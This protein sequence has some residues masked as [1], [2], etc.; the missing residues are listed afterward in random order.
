MI[1]IIYFDNFSRETVCTV[2]KAELLAKENVEQTLLEIFSLHR[3]SFEREKASLYI[4]Y[5]GEIKPF[6]LPL[7]SDEEC[8]EIIV[9][10]V[11]APQNA[12]EFARE[13]GIMYY[14]H[15]AEQSHKCFPHIHAEYS[16]ETISIYLNDFHTVGE[17]KNKKAKE[18]VA[19][20]RKNAKSIKAEWNKIMQSQ[21]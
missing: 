3:Y 11:V 2:K 13:N 14:F 19:F 18:A 16:G 8:S 5:N 12:Q 4:R 9:S 17:M 1:K 7:L 6:S 20:V 21:E 10:M 15:T